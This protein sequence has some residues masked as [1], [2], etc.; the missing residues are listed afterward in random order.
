MYRITTS[1]QSFRHQKYKSEAFSFQTTSEHYH[2]NKY[3][4]TT[5]IRPFRHQNTHKMKTDQLQSQTKIV[6]PALK[7]PKLI[8]SRSPNKCL[9][10]VSQKG[11][12][13]GAQ[14]TRKQH[15]QELQQL[16]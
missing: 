1:V 5:S 4:I 9:E 13:S 11:T 16:S 14:N 2:T 15:I 3:R 6:E 12:Q 8:P 7:L 10:I